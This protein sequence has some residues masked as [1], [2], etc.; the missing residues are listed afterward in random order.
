MFRKL[1]DLHSNISLQRRAA[2]WTCSGA[3][4]LM[5]FYPASFCAQ[6]IC[7]STLSLGMLK[8]LRS[9]FSMSALLSPTHSSQ[10]T[11]KVLLNMST[12]LARVALQNSTRIPNTSTR[13]S[14]LAARKVETERNLEPA[15]PA[16]EQVK[17]EHGK[18]HH[19]QTSHR[20]KNQTPVQH[21][22]LRTEP[23]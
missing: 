9:R 19:H 12:V 23:G 17:R 21:A 7:Q 22:I 1:R 15:S 5:Y 10:E 16:L 13:I 8:K 18:A 3:N 11:R 14:T 2:L 20:Q 4:H 6:L